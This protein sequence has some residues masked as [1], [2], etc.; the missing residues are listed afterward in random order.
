MRGQQRRGNFRRGNSTLLF[1]FVI[2]R[3]EETENGIGV[4]SHTVGPVKSNVFLEIQYKTTR[5]TAL[6][7]VE[8]DTI[9]RC[10]VRATYFSSL[11]G[12]NNGNSGIEFNPLHVG[13]Q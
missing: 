2:T 6:R 11:A 10:T 5:E 1:Q 4:Y 9:V 13:Q 12:G 8:W 3:A 7:R